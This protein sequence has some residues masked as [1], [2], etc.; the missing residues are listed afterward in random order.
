MPADDLLSSAAVRARSMD[1]VN[2]AAGEREWRPRRYSMAL[3]DAY[4]PASI[5]PAQSSV[6]QIN[7]TVYDR[8]ALA[9]RVLGGVKALRRPSGR[10]VKTSIYDF[11]INHNGYT[12]V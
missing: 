6:P 3:V 1:A 11:C 7:G 9:E 8:P 5:G 4:A 2:G 12:C 10:R